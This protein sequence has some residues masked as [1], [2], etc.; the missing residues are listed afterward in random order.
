MTGT[1]LFLFRGYEH[2]NSRNSCFFSTTSLD[3]QNISVKPHFSSNWGDAIY[4]VSKA[5]CEQKEVLPTQDNNSKSLAPFMYCFYKHAGTKWSSG[6][7]GVDLHVL[8]SRPQVKH[9]KDFFGKHQ[10]HWSVLNSLKH[11][12]GLI[13]LS[14]SST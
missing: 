6:D 1:Y 11:S 7:Y 3:F 2:L 14:I 12:F 10:D 4:T 9:E 8:K 13:N 5:R